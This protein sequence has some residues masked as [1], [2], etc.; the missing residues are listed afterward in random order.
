M[1][2]AVIWFGIRSRGLRGYAATFAEPTI[3]MVPLNLV[4]TITRTFSLVVRLFGNVMSGC[5]SSASSS[6][7]SASSSRSR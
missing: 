6:R 3:L 2:I 1:F 5:S 4:E 7:S